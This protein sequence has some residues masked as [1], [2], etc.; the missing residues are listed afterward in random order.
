MD[1]K[2]AKEIEINKMSNEL[3][4]SAHQEELATLKAQLCREKARQQEIANLIAMHAKPHADGHHDI[5][6]NVNKPF[7][8]SGDSIKIFI[9]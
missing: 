7:S 3:R 5:E 2:L 4:N 8:N 6:Q 9:H 1:E